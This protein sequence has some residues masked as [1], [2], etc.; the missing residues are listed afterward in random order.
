[1]VERIGSTGARV[2]ML[3]LH[4]SP[5]DLPGVDD[6]GGM[7]VYLRALSERL[8]ERDVS[9]DVFTRCAGRGVP[10]VDAVGP[11]VRVVQVPAGPCAP[12]PRAD[13]PGFVSTFADAVVAHPARP[14]EGYDLVHAHYWLSAWAGRSVAR[15]WEVP[16]AV[17]FHTLGMM[18]NRARPEGEAPEPSIRLESERAAVAAADRILASTPAEA[19]VLHRGY[20]A[21]PARIRVV[22]PGVDVEL[23]RPLPSAPARGALGLEDRRV[24]LFIGRLQALKGPDLAI[25]A[26][27]EAVARDPVAARDLVLVVVGG[28]SG[29]GRDVTLAALV[30]LARRLEVGDRVRFLPPRRHRDLPPIYAA[31]DALLMPS[32][33]ESFGLVA[34]E[35]QACGVPVIAAGVDGLR[36]AVAGGRSGFLVDGHDPHRYATRLLDVLREPVLAERLSAGG[37]R[38]ARRFPWDRTADGVLGAYDELVPGIMA[39]EVPA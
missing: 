1:M 8:A 30:R 35:A 32:R 36:Y 24:A 10:E 13:L 34:L 21:E 15:R 2:A 12:A 18:K 5:M 9:V 25:R 17:S 29:S 7:N 28:P 11:R 33:S 20:G 26:V 6:S 37:P 27:A 4:T 16:L 22:P 3:S 38:Q 19:A 39:D 23:F 31:A 14:P